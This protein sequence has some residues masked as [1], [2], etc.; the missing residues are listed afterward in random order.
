MTHRLTRKLQG[1]EAL[2]DVLALQYSITMTRRRLRVDVTARAAMRR[3]SVN[4]NRDVLFVWESQAVQDGAQGP[5]S[6]TND[7]SGA[8]TSSDD[9]PRA[10][11]MRVR[12]RGW[13]LFTPTSDGAAT[14]M[15]TC[16]QMLPLVAASRAEDQRQQSKAVG[17]LTDLAL[18]YFDQQIDHAHHAIE[19]LL[20][21]EV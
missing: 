7:T 1:F 10:S 3:F 9:T 4:D 11:S 15:L 8:S 6:S 14:R 2:G 12:E 16:M 19:T 20:M 13:T 5:T 18:E 21:D 17:V